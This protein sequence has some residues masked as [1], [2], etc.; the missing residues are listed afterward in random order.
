MPGTFKPDSLTQQQS[1]LP[2]LLQ[3]ST[4]TPAKPTAQLAGA[5]FKHLDLLGLK[6]PH[7]KAAPPSRPQ[8][9]KMTSVPPS[10]PTFMLADIN[11]I[12]ARAVQ[13]ALAETQRLQTILDPQEPPLVNNCPIVNLTFATVFQ[14][15]NV[16]YFDP[17]PSKKTVEIKDNHF[18]Y[19]NVFSFTNQLQVKASNR[20]AS[21]LRR[22]LNLCLLG[23]A[24]VWYTK[25]L[26]GPFQIGLRKNG[27]DVE[28]WCKALETEFKGLPAVFLEAYKKT[29]YIVGDVR[30]CMDLTDYVQTMILH[31]HGAEIPKNSYQLA[32]VV[33]HYI[34]GLLFQDIQCSHKGTTVEDTIARICKLQ[35]VWFD[36]YTGCQ[37]N[38][39]PAQHYQA[40]PYLGIYENYPYASTQ[41][42][43]GS[44][45]HGNT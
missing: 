9:N 27:N 44:R 35:D 22:N 18:I 30:R 34:D 24:K 29:R 43:Y 19:Y 23:K 3:Q 17:N 11:Q 31:V 12:V 21:K 15:Q 8:A 1:P 16:G 4:L 40:N 41:E 39:A 6:P 32:L 2:L 26:P 38:V 20:D 25:W 13:T 5:N 42:P 33:Y 45:P 10:A 36:T 14:A 37:T 28:E 7:T